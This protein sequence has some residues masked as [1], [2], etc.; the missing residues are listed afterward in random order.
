MEWFQTL[1]ADTVLLTP[2]RRLAAHY[3]HHFGNFQLTQNK[4]SWNGLD[5]LPISSWI[6]RLWKSYTQNNF[7]EHIRL[8]SSNQELLLWENIITQSPD[9]EHLL[10]I[11]ATAELAKSAFGLL[12]Q[13]NID[14][15]NTLLNITQDSRSFLAWAKEFSKICKKNYWIDH[16]TL[17]NVVIENINQNKIPAPKKIVLIGF[18]DISPQYQ[19]LCDTLIAKGTTIEFYSQKTKNSQLNRLS[20]PDTETEIRTMARW[21]KHLYQNKYI[22]HLSKTPHE[23]FLI[24]CI[25]PKLEDMRD[26]VNRI[27]TEVF[28][29]AGYYSLNSLHLP[30]NISAGKTLSRYPVIHTALEIL[31]L[32]NKTISID[33][34][35]N[36]LRSPFLGD[37]E[38]EMLKRSEFDYQLHRDNITGITLKKL[39]DPYARVNAIQSCPAL[40][41]RV[42]MYLEKNKETNT[43]KTISEWV[44]VFVELLLILGWP[45]E[46]TISSEEYQVIQRFTELLNE[47]ET[48]ETIFPEISYQKALNYL[49]RLSANTVFQIQSPSTP[50]QILG[51]L[52]AAE[53]SFTHLWV[54]GM[55]DIN[56]PPAPKPNPFI[57]HSLQKKLNMPHATA[58]RELHF[59]EK[60]IAQIK[61]CANEVL[62]SHAHHNDVGEVHASALIRD[63]PET[64]L[65]ELSLADSIPVTQI[66]FKENTNIENFHDEIAPPI[67]STES[68]RG[69][70]KI[71][72]LQAACPFKAF[73]ELRLYAKPIEITTLGLRSYDRGNIVHKTLEL[74]W[75]EL[76]DSQTLQRKTPD[77]LLQIIE[78]AIATAIF[79]VTG[80]KPENLHY[81]TLERQ[82]LIKIISNWLDLE[83][84]RPHFQVSAHEQEFQI[85]IANLPITL[86]IDRIDSLGHYGKLIIDYKTGKNNSIQDWFGERPD[87]P[88]LI[89][90][91]L[92]DPE[93]TAGIA[94]GIVH[95][96]KMELKGISKQHLNI[97]SISTLDEIKK[98][99]SLFWEEQLTAWR[100]TLE[101]LGTDFYQGIA[102]VDPKDG[103]QTCKH[104]QL[105]PFCRIHEKF[106]G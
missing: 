18:T 102:K 72:E 91:C 28:T 92:I 78:Q 52:E 55:D 25:I 59:C 56:W 99:D 97:N 68:I 1:K 60:I 17:I 67:T 64:N 104:C 73:A 81:L 61:N 27:F 12:T 100:Q 22:N 96:E 87:A 34:L 93:N 10:Q 103:L 13:W 46:R 43:K 85:T 88:Q 2:N 75:T 71:F 11:A 24:G 26:T 6:E 94:F 30:F 31:Q 8:I 42:K 44:K 82:R 76:N 84:Q 106:Y 37:A 66:L 45:G 49:L 62:F 70:A 41:A 54:M 35:S 4:K 14:L 79:K 80:E 40:A 23:N 47:F 48:F 15:N 39:L 69:G 63:L 57:P 83:K 29:E 3:V 51:M 98:S 74:V 65:N 32:Q 86:R 53:I 38:K 58:D 50:I 89:L 105:K 16:T 5:V 19:N 9:S 20:L 77:E 95:P 101:K 90:Y 21:A 33:V 36:L 7:E